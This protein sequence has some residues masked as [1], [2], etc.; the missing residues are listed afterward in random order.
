MRQKL[1]I[2][3]PCPVLVP[4]TDLALLLQASAAGTT[5]LVA[6]TLNEPDQPPCNH[7][8]ARPRV[9]LRLTT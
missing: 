8:A 2:R 4:V 9:Q 3:T 6:L 1:S 5:P 7:A